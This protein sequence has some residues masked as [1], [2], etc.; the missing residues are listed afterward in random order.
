MG[1]QSLKAL[2]RNSCQVWCVH[3]GKDCD[4]NLKHDNA[5]KEKGISW[6]HTTIFPN[7]PAT[8]KETDDENNRSKNDN[9]DRHNGWIVL[10]KNW[11]Y[12]TEFEEWNCTGDDEC[13]AADLQKKIQLIADKTFL[14]GKEIAWVERNNSWEN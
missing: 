2:A 6:D 13:Y 14:M 9:R 5:Q 8:S 7:G 10:R 12:F 11:L 1:E 4:D 3:K